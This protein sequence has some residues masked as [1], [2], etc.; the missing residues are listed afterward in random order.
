MLQED[1][2]LRDSIEGINNTGYVGMLGTAGI[3]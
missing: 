3:P 1:A 2:N